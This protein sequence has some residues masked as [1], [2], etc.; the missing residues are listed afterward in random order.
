MKTAIFTDIHFGKKP[1]DSQFNKDCV[2]FV[3]WFLDRCDENDVDDVVFMG[4]WFHDRFR[5][6]LETHA[7]ADE[8]LRKISSRY[9]TTMIVGNHDMLYRHSRSIHSLE[10]YKDWENVTVID[11]ITQDG[12]RLYVPYMVEG[13]QYE[14]PHVDADVIFGHFEIPT[15]YMNRG[16]VFESDD[17][18]SPDELTTAPLLFSGHFHQRQQKKNS[19]GSTLVYV[20]SPFPHDFN[21][22]DRTDYGMAIL[23]DDTFRFID[24]PD[25]P[26]F[27]R[28]T[29]TQFLDAT[30]EQDDASFSNYVIEITNNVPDLTPVE[31]MEAR[32]FA[33]ELCREV[34]WKETREEIQVNEVDLN[35]ESVSIEDL[36]VEQLRMIES[37]DDI[38]PDLLVSLFLEASNA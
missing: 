22:L 16:K 30:E 6:D 25:A 31:I 19:A 23:D 15:F 34:R 10:C 14:I 17:A 36:V 7:I 2:A 37:R 32:E 26:V 27:K 21:D 9:P 1:G 28:M 8:C 3:D 38:D 35:D 18:L 29:L 20:G 11:E 13:E 5:I 12:A 4:D 33:A 24:W